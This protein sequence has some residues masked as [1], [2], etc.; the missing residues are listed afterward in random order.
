MGKCLTIVKLVG[1]GSLGL[2]S[3]AFF[4]SSKYSIPSIIKSSEAFS[5]TKEKVTTL[6]SKLRLSF[7]GLGSLASWLFYQAYTY[8]P[9]HGKHPYFI[10]AALTFPI[11]LAFNYYYTFNNEQK[12]IKDEEK[13]IVYKK[14][15]QIVKKVITPE[16]ENS[17]LDNSS[18]N[19]L[20]TREPK[21]E[22]TQLEIDVP[23]LEKIEL[24]E[25]SFLSVLSTVSQNYLCSGSI[26]G[27]GFLLAAIGYAGDNLK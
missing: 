18:Y 26:M 21:V 5:E 27:I 24:T 10:Y 9:S 13:R 25:D 23:V 6:I 16:E 20:G 4:L 22:E 11:T 8:S 12:L 1:I 2:S 7:W 14:E 17:P 3:G 15:K 19:D